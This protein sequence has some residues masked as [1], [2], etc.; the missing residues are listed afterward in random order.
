MAVVT[1]TR[2]LHRLQDF[3]VWEMYPQLFEIALEKARSWGPPVV[4]CP[5]DT[6][7][8]ECPLYIEK[9]ERE[10]PDEPRKPRPRRRKR[11]KYVCSR[12]WLRD[13]VPGG[14]ELL[15]LLEAEDAEEARLKEARKA[16]GAPPPKRPRRKR[17]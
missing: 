4:C 2:S 15:A 6:C 10:H 5:Q 11:Y 12:T 16:E 17:E 3:T 1:T 14:E 8:K 7:D 13:H 9:W